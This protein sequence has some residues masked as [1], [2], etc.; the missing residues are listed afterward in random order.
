MEKINK[1]KVTNEDIC[2][3]ENIIGGKLPLEYREF[4][5]KT[6]GGVPK[7]QEFITKDKFVESYLINLLP[8]VGKNEET[9]IDEYNKNNLKQNILQHLIIIGLDPIKSP[10]VISIGKE[11]YGKVYYWHKE[12]DDEETIL[13][14]KN[15]HLIADDFKDLFKILK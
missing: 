11:D 10:I 5:L 8:L 2:N 3:F 7:N 12:F 15:M 4:L 1:E 6:N 9:L 13:S 14:Y